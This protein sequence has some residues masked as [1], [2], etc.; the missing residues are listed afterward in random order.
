MRSK[1]WNDPKL[2]AA[3]FALDRF[4]IA[5]QTVSEQ[6]AEIYQ[7]TRDGCATDEDMRLKILRKQYIALSKEVEDV[8]GRHGEAGTARAKQNSPIIPPA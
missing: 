3:Q 1:K 6:M 7:S 2:D 5:Q 4:L 8:M